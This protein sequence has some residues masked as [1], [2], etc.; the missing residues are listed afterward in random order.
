MTDIRRTLLWVIFSMSLFLIWD[1][2]NK[3]NGQPSF[4]SPPAQATRAAAVPPA[5]SGAGPV[6]AA[7]VPVP[8]GAATP[9]AATAAP[10]APPRDSP[11]TS[12]A[13]A[14]SPPA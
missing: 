3:H 2:W 13:P 10:P 11:K 4:F 5:A 8:S 14:R 6:T 1:A 9:T 7:G 12:A